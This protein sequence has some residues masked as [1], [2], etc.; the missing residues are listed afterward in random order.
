[1]DKEGKRSGQ[2][3]AWS[4]QGVEQARHGAGKAW[5]GQGIEWAS[6]E[7]ARQ[8]GRSVDTKQ[9]LMVNTDNG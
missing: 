2:G 8:E 9:L 5:S 6:Q 1:M 4:G 3:K 7:Q